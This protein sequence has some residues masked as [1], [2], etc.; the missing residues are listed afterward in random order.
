MKLLAAEVSDMTPKPG[1]DTAKRLEELSEKYSRMLGGFKLTAERARAVVAF[2]TRQLKLGEEELAAMKKERDR[3]RDD[4]DAAERG[5]HLRGTAIDRCEVQAVYALADC[6]LILVPR[7]T[8]RSNAEA[9]LPRLY[10]LEQEQ[11]DAI[12]DAWRR[13]SPCWRASARPTS[14][15]TSV[16][17]RPNCRLAPMGWTT[18][19]AIWASAWASRRS[20]PRRTARLRRAPR[21]PAQ[22]G[23]H[24]RGAAGGLRQPGGGDEP[25]V[26]DG[27]RDAAAEP[28]ARGAAR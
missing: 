20:S 1:E 3:I 12:E 24:G 11:V 2:R 28:P 13:A 19:W 25:A 16:R 27:R 7:L 18:C 4:R 10:R 5:P 8:R 9:I 23:G 21:Q 26:A 22:L 15:R 17:R 6:D 14:R